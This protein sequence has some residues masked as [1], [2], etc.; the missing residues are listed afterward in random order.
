[1]IDAVLP[2]EGNPS[3]EPATPATPAP[4]SPGSPTGPR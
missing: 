3:P 4:F 1:M 2:A